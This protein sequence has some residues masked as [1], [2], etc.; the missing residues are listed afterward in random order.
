MTTNLH[1]PLTQLPQ[2]PH[3]S[4]FISTDASTQGLILTQAR[5]NYDQIQIIREELISGISCTSPPLPFILPCWPEN[6]A[7]YE[8]SPPTSE[9]LPPLPSI[10][11]PPIKNHIQ[12][13]TS[14]TSN[15]TSPKPT[16]IP[17]LPG[18]LLGLTT[19]QECIEAYNH[20][21][22]SSTASLRYSKTAI[23]VNFNEYVIWVLLKSLRRDEGDIE[24]E[25]VRVHSTSGEVCR[26]KEWANGRY[27]QYMHYLNLDQC[28]R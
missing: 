7:G 3:P 6:T 10:P 4:T 17:P 1:L 23:I 19:P 20:A 8:L 14:L 12:R 2:L 11:L 28:K 18:Y 22:S 21:E 15:S 13:R 5:Q 27:R 26:V 25:S 16:S 24:V 9:T